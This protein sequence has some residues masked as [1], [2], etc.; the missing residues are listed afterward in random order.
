M[1]LSNE[2]EKFISFVR[3]YKSNLIVFLVFLVVIFYKIFPYTVSDIY[4]DISKPLYRS[5]IR[6]DQ[7]Q[8]KKYDVKLIRQFNMNRAYP[9]SAEDKGIEGKV[10]LKL[11]IDKNGDIE[12]INILESTPKGIF[13]SSA[14]GAAKH[15]VFLPK[16]IDCVNYPSEYKLNILY[17]MD[18]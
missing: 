11:F 6:F 18:D 4:W 13:E 3:F 8:G 10:S 2:L 1:H 5:A 17:K 15:M 14:I 9:R 12:K 7:C 16:T